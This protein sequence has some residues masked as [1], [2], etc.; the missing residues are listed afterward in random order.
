MPAA[1]AFR[2][3]AIGLIRETF[4][5]R[6]ALTRDRVLFFADLY[7]AAGVVPPIEVTDSYELVDGRNRLA[8]QRELGYKTVAVTVYPAADRNTLLA[9]ALNANAGGALPPTH[10]DFIFTLKQMLLQGASE[11]AITGSLQG[12]WPAKYIAGAIRDAR[13]AL[14]HDQIVKA[15]QAVGTG[16]LTVSEAATQFHVSSDALKRELHIAPRT[17]KAS[18][19]EHMAA[20]TRIWTPA[21]RSMGARHRK[22]REDHE[23][24]TL[25]L[26]QVHNL[27]KHMEHH[28][29][30]MTG[31]IRDFKKRIAALGKL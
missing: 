28:A 5:V 23:S 29:R 6:Q 30:L 9:R 17:T 21:S 13:S 20:L 7:K 19:H 12:N 27:I 26:K 14:N 4:Y 16:N 10:S 24:G 25:S 31:N 8:A 2:T 22:I 3:V 1:S 15:V 11:K 18:E